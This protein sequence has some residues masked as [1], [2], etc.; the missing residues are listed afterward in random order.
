MRAEVV[1][2]T[3]VYAARHC[4]GFPEYPGHGIGRVSE[5]GLHQEKPGFR[6]HA[7]EALE[8]CPTRYRCD[9]RAV[10]VCIFTRIG[11]IRPACLELSRIELATPRRLVQQSDDA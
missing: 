9:V 1:S 7:F 2:Q 8:E 3:H 6:R 10:A 11:A 4:G 5:I